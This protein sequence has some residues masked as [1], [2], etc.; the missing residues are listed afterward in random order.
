MQCGLA[1]I[2]TSDLQRWWAEPNARLQPRLFDVFDGLQPG[3]PAPFESKAVRTPDGRLWFSNAFVVQ[4]IDPAHLVQ[5][6]IPPPV[7]VEHIIADHKGYAAEGDI[8]LPARTRDVE[9]DYTR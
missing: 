8:H 2:T 5:N 1:E 3:N 4:T 7:H 6:S 9:I